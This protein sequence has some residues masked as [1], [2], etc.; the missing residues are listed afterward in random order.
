MAYPTAVNDQVTDA[1]TQATVLSI[2][3]APASAMGTLTQ[4]IANALSLASG[5]ATVAQQKGWLLAEAA[6]AVGVQ[7]IYSTAPKPPK[8]P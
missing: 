3:S 8:T 7:L 5:N 2:G 6:A 1:V 4:A